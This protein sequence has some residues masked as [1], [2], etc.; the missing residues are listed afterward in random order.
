MKRNANSISLCISLLCW[1]VTKRITFRNNP[2]R[3][4]PLWSPY[5]I[6]TIQGLLPF[7]QQSYLLLLQHT[8]L[9]AIILA[10]LDKQ[11]HNC[12]VHFTLCNKQ[13][14]RTQKQ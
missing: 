1:C 10:I 3:Q 8:L 9:M 4:K 2:Q 14:Y 13:Y 7:A 6:N 12:A 11:Q 5:S